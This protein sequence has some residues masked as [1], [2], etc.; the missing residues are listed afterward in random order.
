MCGLR[1]IPRRAW[2]LC[3]PARPCLCG[4]APCSV[5]GKKFGAAGEYFGK[6]GVAITTDG[7]AVF[8]AYDAALQT[9]A[10][11]GAFPSVRTFNSPTVDMLGTPSPCAYT[12][13]AAPVRVRRSCSVG[14]LRR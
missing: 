1:A 12:L 5:G 4:P 10:R 6:D 3:A 8:T 9:E 13:L 14:L 11:Y 7:G 2:A